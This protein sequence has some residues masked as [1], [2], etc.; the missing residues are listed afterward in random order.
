[1]AEK[2]GLIR[3]ESGLDW[4]EQWSAS[5]GQVEQN[6]VYKAL[7]AVADGSV[8]WTY[9]TFDDMERPDQ[10]FV[11]VRPELVIKVAF[12]GPESFGIVY[13]GTPCGAPGYDLDVDGTC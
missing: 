4:L 3:L 5:A 7:F 11:L 2:S 13:I 1:V 6:A 10:F 8:L 9:L 12:R